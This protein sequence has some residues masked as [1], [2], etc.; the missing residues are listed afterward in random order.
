MITKAEIEEQKKIFCKNK[1]YK[2][3]TC[4]GRFTFGTGCR[5]CE[6]C[7]DELKI[8][9]DSHSLVPKLIEA[10]EKLSAGIRKADLEYQIVGRSDTAFSHAKS[11]LQEVWGEDG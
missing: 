8:L 7:L 11:A 5:K 4:R 6:R 10:V 1:S 9:G 2:G 3:P